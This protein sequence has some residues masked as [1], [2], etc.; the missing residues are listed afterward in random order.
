MWPDKYF[1]QHRPTNYL[2]YPWLSVRHLSVITA[3]N[4]PISVFTQTLSRVTL[5]LEQDHLVGWFLPWSIWRGC[6]FF[7][8]VYAWVSIPRFQRPSPTPHS[9]P[10]LLVPAPLFVSI[11]LYLWR[12][13]EL[14][15]YNIS[16]ACSHLYITVR[17]QTKIGK[18]LAQPEL[19]LVYCCPVWSVC[20]TEVT[21]QKM[22]KLNVEAA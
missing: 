15:A 9:L 18:P 16:R 19:L 12:T 10:S 8:L 20:I 5:I 4:K 7:L 14:V 22:Y 17:P 3:G 2:E 1:S 6:S 21:E 13:G 11:F